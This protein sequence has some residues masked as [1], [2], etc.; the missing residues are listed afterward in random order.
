MKI[1][2]SFNNTNI[3][4]SNKPINRISKSVDSS[5][6]NSSA[7]SNIQ[8]SDYLQ[9]H[10]VGTEPSLSFNVAKVEEIKA[11]IAEG[12]YQISSKAIAESLLTTARDILKAQQNLK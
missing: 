10:N 7:N 11:A 6:I 1:D 4:I 8:K 5:E 3:Q 2:S 12:R 9:L